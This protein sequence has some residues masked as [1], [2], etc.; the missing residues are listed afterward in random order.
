[1]K[2][3]TTPVL[4]NSGLSR[5]AE[6]L[7]RLGKIQHCLEVADNEQ[8]SVCT[9]S[10]KNNVDT[11][12]RLLDP[13]LDDVIDTAV[14]SAVRSGLQSEI[15]RIVDELGKLGITIEDSIVQPLLED[16]L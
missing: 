5:T 12:T 13:H 7:A 6:L 8:L 11:V 1:M 15:V 16:G 14:S 10:T 9:I 4:I 3:N 2:E